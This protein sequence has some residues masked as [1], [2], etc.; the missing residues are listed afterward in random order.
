MLPYETEVTGR[1]ATPK[2]GAQRCSGDVYHKRIEKV[3]GAAVRR[4]GKKAARQ[5]LRKMA[6]LT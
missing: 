3:E 6:R 1:R 5:A 2:N 4:K